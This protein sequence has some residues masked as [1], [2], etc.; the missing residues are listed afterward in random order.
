MDRLPSPE[1]TVPM[2][3]RKEDRAEFARHIYVALLAR[4]ELPPDGDPNQIA[5]LLKLHI[6][7]FDAALGAIKHPDLL[8]PDDPVAA[9]QRRR[10][11]L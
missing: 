11:G 1:L 7:R 4:G 9:R 8:L 5:D 6:D 2:K 10:R 3:F